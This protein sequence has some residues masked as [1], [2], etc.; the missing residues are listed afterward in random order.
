MNWGNMKIQLRGNILF[1]GSNKKHTKDRGTWNILYVMQV[2]A[3]SSFTSSATRKT[4]T[5]QELTFPITWDRT[6]QNLDSIIHKK[7]GTNNFLLKY[8]KFDVLYT[9]SSSISWLVRTPY[10]GISEPTNKVSS[11]TSLLEPTIFPIS[12]ELPVGCWLVAVDLVFI[13]IDESWYERFEV[14]AIFLARA[15]SL[16]VP[17]WD[18]GWV[19]RLIWDANS[20]PFSLLSSA[21]ELEN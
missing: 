15:W 3:R 6:I 1:Y 10:F 17:N 21:L 4:S 14:A 20:L 2:N 16:F 13:T 7:V 18:D 9:F 19:E 5:P 12:N 11:V 8:K